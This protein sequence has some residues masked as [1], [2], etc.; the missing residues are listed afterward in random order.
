MINDRCREV[1]NSLLKG[2][3]IATVMAAIASVSRTNC[4]TRKSGGL[5]LE[6]GSMRLT[7]QGYTVHEPL[8]EP[9]LDAPSQALTQ[10]EIDD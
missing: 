10:I 6:C 8:Q 2:L 7:Q 4:L 1:R 9:L 3:A 5:R